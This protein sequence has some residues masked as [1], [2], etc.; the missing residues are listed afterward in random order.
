MIVMIPRDCFRAQRLRSA[1]EGAPRREE[2]RPAG[3]AQRSLQGCRRRSTGYFAQPS[4]AGRWLAKAGAR[5]IRKSPTVLDSDRGRLLLLPHLLR[6][7]LILLILRVLLLRLLL[8]HLLV[9]RLR[10]SMLRLTTYYSRQTTYYL[11]P[12]MP[13]ACCR[14]PTTCDQVCTTCCLLH[15][16]DYR[17]PTAYSERPNKHL[18]L[19][20]AYFRCDSGRSCGPARAR[21]APADAC[22]PRHWCRMARVLWV[23]VLW[24]RVMWVRTLA[25]P[26]SSGTP[27]NV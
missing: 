20:A 1:A 14:W 25:N 27:G 13:S 19:R 6:L 7:L 3:L 26:R 12:S 23:R 4:G 2:K 22:Q 5:V 24:A 10:R 16:T 8:P 18:L 15:T 17:L 11:L 9:L 21:P